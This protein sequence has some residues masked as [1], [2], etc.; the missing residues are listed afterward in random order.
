MTH[1]EYIQTSVLKEQFIE[2]LVNIN[3]YTYMYAY[4][5]EWQCVVIIKKEVKMEM[6]NE[7]QGFYGLNVPKHWL[8]DY[9]DR[10]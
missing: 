2:I 4:N 8:S 1:I 3:Q 7:N 6:K 10:L 5:V 9:A